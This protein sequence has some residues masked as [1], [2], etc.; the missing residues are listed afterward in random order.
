MTFLYRYQDGAN[1]REER[2]KASSESDAYSLLRKSGVRPMKVWPAPG[3]LNRV[4]ALG[5]RGLAIIVLGVLCL[6]LGAVVLSWSR[7]EKRVSRWGGAVSAAQTA[8]RHQI[9]GDPALISEMEATA[10]ASVFTHPGERL[11]AHYAQP[12]HRV[13]LPPALRASHLALSSSLTNEIAIVADNPREIQELKSIVLGMKDELREY[14]AN[15]VGT[16]E[17]YLRRLQE[18]QAE[19]A[20]IYEREANALKNIDDPAEYERVNA[21]LRRLGLRTIPAGKGEG[22]NV[23]ENTP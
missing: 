11:L 9:Y 8:P 20:A 16:T 21:G 12:G 1:V 5:K 10:Y 19:E 18:R 15:G 3:I 6:V 22:K 2:I 17:S 23:P 13:T 4:S 7:T 14:L